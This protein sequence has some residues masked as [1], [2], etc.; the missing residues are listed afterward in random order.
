MYKI[1]DE[2]YIGS[3]VE[4]PKLKERNFQACLSISDRFELQDNA[5]IEI[6]EKDVVRHTK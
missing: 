2:V 4:L 5:S 6:E 1:F 3:V